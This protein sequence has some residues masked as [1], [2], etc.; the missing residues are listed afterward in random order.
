MGI[1]QGRQC[2]PVAR[3]KHGRRLHGGRRRRIASALRLQR[4]R[5]LLELALRLLSA[6]HAAPQIS[7]GARPHRLGVGL[8]KVAALAAIELRHR[9]HQLALGLALFR[10]FQTFGHRQRGIVPRKVLVG[11]GRHLAR[12]GGARIGAV[13]SKIGREEAV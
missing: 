1:D 8:T 3:A 2:R 10:K 5:Q 11:L 6:R 12:R 4:R 13:E 9:R 7:F